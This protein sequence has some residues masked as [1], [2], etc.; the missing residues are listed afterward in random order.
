MPA[1]LEPFRDS[2]AARGVSL[3][4][5]TPDGCAGAV[6]DAVGESSAVGAP[7]PAKFGSLPA[8]VTTR[9]TTA[10]LDDAT[11]GVTPAVLGV[12][13]YG[14]VLLESDPEGT[15]LASLYPERHVAVLRAADV[16]ADMPAAFDRLG[17]RLREERGS[18]VFAT[19]P[20]A[21]ADM[22][23]LVLGAHGPK[24][25]HVVLVH[26]SDDDRPPVGGDAEE[27]AT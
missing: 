6:A 24:A 5:T 7:L 15:E 10:E 13:D 17:P 18:V 2:L 12:A 23:S 20:S 1:V 3:S 16:V 25:V 22:G 11:T 26:D 27:G 19:G 4:E 21:T 8:A 14:S 9:P